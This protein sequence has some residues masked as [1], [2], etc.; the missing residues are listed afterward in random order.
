MSNPE[1]AAE[2]DAQPTVAD[3]I[4]NARIEQITVQLHGA[5]LAGLGRGKGAA[6]ALVDEL[7]SPRVD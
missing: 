3:T 7:D 1:V 4:R 6:E 2:H 5:I